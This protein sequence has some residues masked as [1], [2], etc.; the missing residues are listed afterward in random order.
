MSQSLFINPSAMEAAL[1]AA[2]VAK[3]STTD[4]QRAAFERYARLGM[5]NRRVEGW[6]WSDFHAATRG[7][8]FEDGATGKTVVAPSVFASLDPIECVILDGRI[9]V[10]ECESV[11]GLEFGIIEPSAMDPEFDGMRWWRS[12]WR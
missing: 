6:K 10:P 9:S 8:K 11:E 5:P 7:I 3:A 1:E 4:A 2:I 12:M